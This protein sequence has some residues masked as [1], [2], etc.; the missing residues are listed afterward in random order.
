MTAGGWGKLCQIP[1]PARPAHTGPAAWP[2]AGLRRCLLRAAAVPCF[3]LMLGGMKMY[4]IWSKQTV[5]S[6][7]PPPPVIAEFSTR[8]QS[9]W[10][11]LCGGAVGHLQ[12][13][14]FKPCTST[15][16][17]CILRQTGSTGTLASGALAPALRL[18]PIAAL[19]FP[20]SSIPWLRA[21]AETHR[22]DPAP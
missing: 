11:V 17:S 19:C 4:C 10:T 3:V 12:Q 5:A 7:H 14:S 18:A 20:H 8:T 1:S 2:S 9:R 13:P 21:T 6:P 16:R 22:G 15:A